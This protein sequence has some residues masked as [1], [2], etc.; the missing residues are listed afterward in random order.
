[1]PIWRASAMEWWGP[2]ANHATDR[3]CEIRIDGRTIS[4]SYSDGGIRHLWQGIEE[5]EGHFRL[6]G[7]DTYLSHRIVAA[8]VT[9]AR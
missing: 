5:T 6:G 3:P 1:M 8:I 7:A 4:L 9:T 2:R